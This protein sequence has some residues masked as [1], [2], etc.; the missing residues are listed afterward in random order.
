MVVQT[1]EIDSDVLPQTIEIKPLAMTIG[2][3]IGGVDLS[4]PL[5]N[6][7]IAEIRAAF[8]KWKVVFFRDQPMDHTQQVAFSRQFGTCTP[9]HAVYGHQDD[10]FPEVYSIDRD[11]RDKRYKGED[12][13]LPWSGWHADVTPAINP[14]AVSILRGDTMPP[15]GGDTQFTDLVAAYK[16][17]SPTMREFVDGLRGIH[18]YQGNA[19]ANVS[20]EYV[21]TLNKNRIVSEHPLVR[22]HPE[23]GERALY[24]S[25]S[26]LESIVG[27]TPTESSTLL[28]L[29]KTHVAR[30]EFT[31]RFM[32]SDH[33]LAM[34]DNR[35]VLHLGPKDIIN[36]E[37]PRE[38]HRTTLMGDIP[39]G[40][41][42]RKSTPIDGEAIK[43]V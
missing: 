28:T 34:W 21:E 32:W 43:P 27:L 37:H 33:A 29:L 40:P 4:K 3:E 35:Q 12:L 25:P 22:V 5:S 23:T 9:A 1:A 15:Y 17:L 7:E 38:I 2:A 14:P 30:P 10:A 36:S 42:G 39:I 19:A 18:R 24:V 13:V 41:D 31:V 8:L 6:Q 11:R 26:F 16:A 20:K